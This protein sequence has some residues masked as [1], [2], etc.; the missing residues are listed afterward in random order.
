MKIRKSSNEKCKSKHKTQVT[1]TFV[2]RNVF[3]LP[4]TNNRSIFKRSFYRKIF[5]VTDILQ[6]GTFR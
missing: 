6:V 5:S 2:N 4:E 1:K 3:F